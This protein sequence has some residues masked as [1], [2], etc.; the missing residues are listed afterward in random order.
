MC[1]KGFHMANQFNRKLLDRIWYGCDGTGKPLRLGCTAATPLALMAVDPQRCALG[2]A[3]SQA[4]RD[5]KTMTGPSV[6]GGVYHPAP[7]GGR[8]LR[9]RSRWHRPQAADD[10]HGVG[11]FRD[12]T[13]L[14]CVLRG[15]A[16]PTASGDPVAA[17]SAHGGTD[18]S[19]CWPEVTPAA[20][21]CPVSVESSTYFRRGS[22]PNCPAALRADPQCRT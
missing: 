9:G 18:R 21:A 2:V 13:D 16:F 12:E 6:L 15:R 7:I 5:I 19:R 10:L 20:R 22:P 1:R 4:Q 3:R 17:G 14:I 8:V 11:E